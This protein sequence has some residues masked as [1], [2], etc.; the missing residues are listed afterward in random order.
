MTRCWTA[1]VARR[2]LR[3]RCIAKP[4]GLWNS[5]VSRRN[6]TSCRRTVERECKADFDRTKWPCN[7]NAR[8]CKSVRLG[9]GRCLLDGEDALGIQ[10]R[11]EYQLRRCSQGTRRYHGVR[12]NTAFRALLRRPRCDWNWSRILERLL[13]RGWYSDLVE[14]TRRRYY[15]GERVSNRLSA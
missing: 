10:Q 15:Q 1:Q 6:G 2:R 3:V 12:I 14:S 13:T 9:G 8:K 5:K 11:L 7:V 4:K